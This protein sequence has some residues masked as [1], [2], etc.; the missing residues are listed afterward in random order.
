MHA[1]DRE[2]VRA[3][4]ARTEASGEPFSVEYRSVTRDGRTVWFRDEA[5]LVVGEDG[6]RSSGRA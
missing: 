3:E 1:D 6:H 5:R 2:R 4:N